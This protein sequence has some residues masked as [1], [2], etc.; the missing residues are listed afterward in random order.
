M[1]KDRKKKAILLMLLMIFAS[2]MLFGCADNNG[3]AEQSSGQKQEQKAGKTTDKK[4]RKADKPVKTKN[5]K[6]ASEKQKAKQKT[7]NQKNKNSSAKKSQA[8]VSKAKT[9]GK[10]KK[11]NPGSIAKSKASSK[12]KTNHK[13][14]SEDTKECTLV[15]ECTVLLGR[16]DI[17]PATASLVPGDGYI[18]QEKKVEVKSGDT[19]YSVLTRA[20]DKYGFALNIDNTQFGKYI[21]GIAGIEEKSCGD[22]SGWKYKVDGTYPGESCSEITVSGGEKIVWTFVLKA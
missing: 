8:P 1:K 2:T 11:K 7:T 18:L 4:A 13:E 19:V 17:D 15:I 20:R 6:K 16:D 10:T 21:A 5:S 14:Q 12:A 3:S 22:E 9:A